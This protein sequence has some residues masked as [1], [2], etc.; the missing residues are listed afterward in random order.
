MGTGRLEIL[1]A[2]DRRGS[3]LGASG[4]TG[5]PY[6]KMWGAIRDME[7]SLGHPLVIKSRG[8]NQGGG[9]SLTEPARDLMKRFER[10]QDGIEESVDSK[11]HTLFENFFAPR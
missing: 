5:I 7:R 9:A 11:F 8:G 4:D 6:R 1:Q 10:L 2:I 3:I